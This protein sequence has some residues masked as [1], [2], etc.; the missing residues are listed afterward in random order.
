MI[1]IFS[2][3]KIPS[4]FLEALRLSMNYGFVT[5]E[6][7]WD[8]AMAS[9]KALDNYD[10]ILLELIS[11]NE[12]DARHIDYAIR[13]RTENAKTDKAFRILVSFISQELFAENLSSNK[14][15]RDLNKIC[16]ELEIDE[17]DWEALYVFDNDLYLADSQIIGDTG[18]IEADL[19][20]IIEP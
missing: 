17:T 13:H 1:Q 10:P 15:A 19:K 20:R 11:G 12:A 8:W 18:Q 14:A 7:I 6:E 4:N 2:T 16:L 5:K 9:I 3:D